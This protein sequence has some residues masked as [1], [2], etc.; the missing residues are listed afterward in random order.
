M[1]HCEV[2]RGIALTETLSTINCSASS[3]H[4]TGLSV[5]SRTDT[6]SWGKQ[7]SA[8]HNLAFT[9]SFKPHS[10]QKAYG[11]GKL[12]FQVSWA[13]LQSHLSPWRVSII[14]GLT[15]WE[16]GSAEFPFGFQCMTH[17]GL[18]RFFENTSVGGALRELGWWWQ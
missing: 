3:L 10:F 6:H 13:S 16:L 2:N 8:P 4:P 17:F 14:F 12:G 1:G 7:S 18:A 15:A 9:A 11:S 5:S